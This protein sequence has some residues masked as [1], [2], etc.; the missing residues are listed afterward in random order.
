M[1]LVKLAHHIDLDP[2]NFPIDDEKTYELFQRGET[3]GIFQYESNGMQKYMKELKPTVFGD[4]IAMNALYRPGPLEYIPSFVRR[5][6][7]EEEIKYDL[8]ACEEYLKETYGITVYQEQVMLLSQKLAGFTKGEADVL[9]KAMGKKQK[10][11][12]DKMKPKF[13]GKA[14]EKGHDPVILEKIWKDWEA[15]ASY[16][17]NKSHS[18]CYAWIAY[19]T[20][21]LKAHYPAEYMAAVLSNN[22]SD[23]KQVAFF[24]EECKQMGVQVLGPDVNESDI[25][26]SVNPQGEV[27]F[28]LSGIKGVGEKAV[29]SIIEDRVLNGMY[30]DVYDFARR[31]N[32]RTVNKK[33]YES[34]VYSGAFDG[35]GHHRAQYFFIGANDKMNGT[36][37]LIK[38]ANDFQNNESSSQSSLFGGSIADLILEPALPVAPEWSLIDRLKYEKDAIGIFLSGH[39]LDNYLLELKEFC[40]QKVKHLSLVNKIRSGDT[41]EEVLAEFEGIKNRELVVGGL[42]VVAAQRMTKTG[43]PFGTIVFED[44]DD[45]CELALFGDDF[46][47]FKQ[48]LTDGYFLQI[49]GRVAERFRKEGDWEFKITSINL[50]SELRDK[51]AKCVTIQVPIERI[52]DDFMSQINAILEDNKSSTD[53]QNCQLLFDIYD[54]EQNVNIKMPSK[55]VKINPNNHFLEQ[56]I[57]LNVNPKLN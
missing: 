14:A 42:V 29:E 3:I 21:Y 9:R 5:K 55:S 28:G 51:L 48:F 46:I 45:T 43:K 16:A 56:L 7:G 23:I 25:K 17:F 36:E 10:D 53:Q 15:F 57:A 19:Q 8:D 30:K 11:V 20:A 33:A 34:F 35:F 4:L 31:S 37:K 12:L 1:K 38:Y 6:N 47:K 39:P 26:F 40:Q 50:L 32:T 41:N 13:V 52:S 49:R 18:T 2:D 22:M 24:M 27:R 44:Y 54:R